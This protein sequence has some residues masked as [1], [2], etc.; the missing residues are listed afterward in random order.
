ML[1]KRRGYAPSDSPAPLVAPRRSRGAPRYSVS[2]AERSLGYETRFGRG[3]IS[4]VFAVALSALGLGGVLCL[5]FPSLLTTPDAR[6]LYPLD[7]VR[8][9][10]H[11][12]LVAG[13]GLGVL[14]VVLS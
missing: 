1:L 7:L 9:L 12:L 5:R 10:I 3:F 11:L 2:V 13:F 14:S 8:F 4:G 6:A